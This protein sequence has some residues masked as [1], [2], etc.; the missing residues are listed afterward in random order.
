[1]VE[2][3][4]GME[5][6]LR[7]NVRAYG[8][9]GCGGDRFRLA[10]FSCGNHRAFCEGC[11]AFWETPVGGE[12]DY[13]GGEETVGGARDESADVVPEA[14]GDRRR[15]LNS[16]RQARWRAAQKAKRRGK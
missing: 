16:A 10:I 9:C 12:P 6:P 1:M 4:A 13:A 2:G 7:R 5:E 15:R 11:E 14:A 8:V 3:D